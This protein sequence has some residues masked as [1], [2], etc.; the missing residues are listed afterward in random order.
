[1]D[2]RETDQRKCTVLRGDDTFETIQG[3]PYR[4]GI[5]RETVSSL[6]LSM[7]VVSIPP[8][9]RA[10][11]HRHAF[12][13]SALYVV[14][15]TAEMWYGEGLAERMV[16]GPRDLIYVPPG[17]PHVSVNRSETEPVVGVVA[18]SDAQTQENVILMPELD[19]LVD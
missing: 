18:R 14:S 17:C 6:N 19:G 8:G 5:S 2:S 4:I 13:E 16:L 15:G 12:H 7:H 9:G 10:Q 3:L 1:M 11:A